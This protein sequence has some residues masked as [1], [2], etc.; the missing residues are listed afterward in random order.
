[1]MLFKLGL[2]FIVFYGKERTF[3]MEAVDTKVKFM[4]ETEDMENIPVPIDPVKDKDFIEEWGLEMDI[5]PD[6]GLDTD[7]T[8]AAEE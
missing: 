1:M 2:E 6:A 3:M 8:V 7:E 5:D 4:E